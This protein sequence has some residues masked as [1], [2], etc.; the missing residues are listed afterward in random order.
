MQLRIQDFPDGRGPTYEFLS[1]KLLFGEIYQKMHE[2]RHKF[3]RE[4]Y[5]LVALVDPP[6]INENTA[7]ALPC[8]VLLVATSPILFFPS[9]T[10]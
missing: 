10:T 5:T 2:K 3:N 6:M 7:Y 8:T 1:K 9:D 4:G